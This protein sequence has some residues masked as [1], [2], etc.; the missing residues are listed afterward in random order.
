MNPSTALA[1]VLVDELI[2][3]GVTDAVLAP[4]SRN[5]P[6]SI[7]LFD[8][9]STGRVRLHVRIDERTAGFLAVGLAR[10]TGRPVPIVTTSG[11]AVANLHPAVLEAHHGGVPLLILSSDRPP[12]LRDVGANQVV[13]QRGLFGPALRFFHEFGVAAA[14]PGQNA[15]WR[16]M[17]CRALAHTRGAGTGFGGPVQ[18]NV[19]LVEPLLPDDDKAWPESLHH[20]TA[21]GGHPIPWTA[22]DTAAAD[23]VLSGV[24]VPLGRVPMIPAPADGERVLF[25]GDLTHPAAGPLAALGHVVLSEAGGAAGSAVVSAGLHLLAVPGFLEPALPDRV[26]VLGRPTMYRQITTLLADS[27]I[28]V[29]VLAAPFGYA[30]P[31][32]KARRVAPVLAPLAG[33][34][35][36]EFVQIWRRAQAVARAQVA[37]QVAEMDIAHSPRLAADLVA[38]LPD[39]STLM[40][41]SSQPPRDVGL[42]AAPRDGLRLVANRGVAGIDGTISTAVGVA[43][44]SEGPTVALMGDLTF[45]HDLTG[46]VIGPHEPRPDLTIVVSNNGGGGIFHT[47][48]PGEP[49]H[50]RAFE[51][52]FGTPHDVQLAGLVEAAGWEHVFVTSTDELADALADPS[53]IRVVEVPTS[54]TD[55]R[56]VHQRIRT[57]VSAAVRG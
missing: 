46:L 29:D 41:G 5:A 1:R 3:G 51:R 6:L 7:A 55:L 38:L 36:T 53:G 14:T 13:D 2:N 33:P 44:G 24:D 35:D 31:T 20:R 47:L 30:D 32:G 54:R 40:L 28:E 9:D 37:A 56:E 22:I 45:L 39:G 48:E 11:T 27:M 34:G 15:I 4:G 18:L 57:A 8:A 12:A 16:S 49:L 19:P 10:S 23:E 52:V 25:L 21:A 17:V 42:A 50:A 26:V 43:L